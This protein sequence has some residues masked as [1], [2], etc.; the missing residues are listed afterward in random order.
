MSKIEEVKKIINPECFE[1]FIQ[2]CP[3]CPI[4]N[5]P[6]C[7]NCE[8]QAHQICKLFEPKSEMKKLTNEEMM[9][10]PMSERHKILDAQVKQFAKDHPNYPDTDGC[11]SGEST[12]IP[13]K[14]DEVKPKP[15]ESRL[16]TDDDFIQLFTEE[17]R[18]QGVP[19]KY[20]FPEAI[21]GNACYHRVL[22]KAQDAK[23]AS[24][25]DAECQRRV[26]RIFEEIEEHDFS[27]DRYGNPLMN[28]DFRTSDGRQYV[29]PWWQ[30]LKKREA[31]NVET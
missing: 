29:A 8:K 2:I 14:A 7:Q 16:L 3:I 4:P 9:K 15:D 5:N 1:P 12:C 17:Q 31:K 28:L 25:K 13:I 27:Y 22:A 30:A 20:N 24:I 26:E 10:L 21:A 18:T 6:A 23:T 11:M 19:D